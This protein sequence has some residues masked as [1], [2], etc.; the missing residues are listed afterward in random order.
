[1]KR[2]IDAN[3]LAHKRRNAK[4]ADETEIKGGD[5]DVSEGTAETEHGA[6]EGAVETEHGALE[7][8][9]ETEHGALESTVETEYGA[10][11]TEPVADSAPERSHKS[12][13]DTDAED[14]SEPKSINDDTAD[15]GDDSV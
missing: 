2:A 3:P 11:E 8:A 13:T 9:T 12:I 7:G 6:L 1:M 5:E 4:R 14:M 10:T 15:G